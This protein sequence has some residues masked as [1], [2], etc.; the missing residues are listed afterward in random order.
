M[1]QTILQILLTIAVIAMVLSLWNAERTSR[2][3]VEINNENKY[4]EIRRN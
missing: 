1:Y 4:F 2:A 3:E